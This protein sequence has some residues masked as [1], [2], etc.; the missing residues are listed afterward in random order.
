MLDLDGPG[1]LVSV[2]GIR[3]PINKP[4]Q[5]IKGVQLSLNLG[6]VAV[7]A[8]S[9][10]QSQHTLHRLIDMLMH[11]S[12]KKV[13][14]ARCVAGTRTPIICVGHKQRI[15]VLLLV[16]SWSRS[17]SCALLPLPSCARLPVASHASAAS[18]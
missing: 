16:R 3:Q 9:M 4:T 18:L 11:K 14:T 15:L 1:I 17:R 8:T 2:N 5:S 6:P 10:Q 12:H 7:S 13:E